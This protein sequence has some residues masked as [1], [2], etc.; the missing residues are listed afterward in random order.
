[1]KHTEPSCGIVI[2]AAGLG[3]RMH[4]DKAKVLHEVGG[5]SMVA[6]VTE[7]ATRIA[8][9]RVVVVV[10]HQADEVRRAV[11]ES[12]ATPVRFALQ[13][14][15]LGTGHA[16]SCALPLIDE[17]V[18]DVVILYGDVPLL[19]PRTLRSLLVDHGS[20]GRDLTLLT[21]EMTDPTGYGR[22]LTG[23]GGR[24]RGIVE[25]ADASDAQKQIRLIN[26]GIYCVKHRF[27]VEA[28]PLLSAENAQGEYYL[29]DIVA[30]GHRQGRRMGFSTL[31][32]PQ[33]TIGVNSLD[34]L[35][36]VQRIYLG[37][38]DSERRTGR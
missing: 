5:R 21:A 11:S 7:T 4:S 10:G 26:T 27:L 22:I 28:L 30:I 19:R 34:E 20:A 6:I 3:K 32:D 25:E 8:E 31:A 37:R 33:E 9:N 17:A 14:Q 12:V 38:P 2:L 29:T 24:L 18:E 35:D 13:A 1:M 15:Q 16:V 23:D 36:K